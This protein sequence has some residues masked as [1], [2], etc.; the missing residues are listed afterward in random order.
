MIRSVVQL[1]RGFSFGQ[2]ESQ[3]KDVAELKGP[4]NQPVMTR[5]MDGLSVFL[6]SKILLKSEEAA[7]FA[8]LSCQALAIHLLERWVHLWLSQSGDLLQS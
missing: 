2:A 4:W 5:V 3:I 6:G 8:P 7:S 1:R